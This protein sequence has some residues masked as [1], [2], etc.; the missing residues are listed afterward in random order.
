MLYA[1]VNGEEAS[2]N[3][4][5]NTNSFPLP[6]EPLGGKGKFTRAGIIRINQ[7]GDTERALLREGNVHSADD[8]RL[9][10]MPV[11]ERYRSLNKPKFFRGDAAFAIPDL[12]ELLEA[13]DYKYAIRL[14]E[15]NILR[16]HTSP[17]EIRP[18][19]RPPKRPIIRYHSFMYQA[20]SWHKQRRVIAKI[21][22]H[23]EELFAR[24]NFVVTNLTWSAKRV[25]RFYNGRGTAEQ[26]IKEG[27]YALNWTRLSCS[28]FEANQA[29]LPLFTLAYNL[30]NF[31]RRLALPHRVKHWSLRS[32]QT[33]L[34]KIG[35]KVIQHARYARFQLAEVAVSRDLFRAILY[36]IHG[37]SPPE[38]VPQ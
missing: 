31:L 18:V 29:R 17:W 30:G 37:L 15:N 9:V 4:A 11:I 16:R 27:K 25:V 2:N 19:G 12:Y 23:A 35:A 24:V 7:G 3:V 8:W 28:S 20:K 26:W 34:I 21:E 10:L 13:E 6:T 14:P 38:Q 1:L 33:K 32:L 36:K 5:S 22:F